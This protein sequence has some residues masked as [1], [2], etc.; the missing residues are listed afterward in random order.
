[1]VRVGAGAY[2]F[3][4]YFLVLLKHKSVNFK[5]NVWYNIYIDMVLIDC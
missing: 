1:M 4:N 3:E 5:V 2:T